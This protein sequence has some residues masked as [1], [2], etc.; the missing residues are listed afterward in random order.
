MH[1]YFATHF[2]IRPR[3]KHFAEHGKCVTDPYL[4]V[5]IK[6]VVSI[7]CRAHVIFCLRRLCPE[8]PAG[9]GERKGYEA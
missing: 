8:L 6:R 4:H 5:L 1:T 2:A 3:A 9:T 7:I